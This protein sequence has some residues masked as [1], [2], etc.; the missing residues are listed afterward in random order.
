MRIVV[1]GK[2]GQLAQALAE[3]GPAAGATVRMLGRPEFDLAHPENAREALAAL[4]PDVVV[5]AAAYTAV[6]KAEDEPQIA[7]AVNAGGPRALAR[8]AAELRVPLIHVSTDYVFDGT[9]PA[10]WTEDDAPAPLGVY[11]AS[12]RAGEVAVLEEAPGSVVLRIGWVYS[13][14]ATNFAKTVLRLAG[15]R[16]VLRIVD[17]QHGGPTSALDAADGILSVARNIAARR[18]H[19]TLRGI[20]HMGPAGEATWAD[21]AAAVCTWLAS[22][23]GRRAAVERIATADYPTKARRPA[24]SRLDSR[25][26]AEA[27]GVRLP[28]WRLSLPKVLERLAPAPSGHSPV[29]TEKNA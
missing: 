13:P 3:R 4:E 17:D 26:L 7:F 8:A 2:T 20:F 24:N 18:D 29:V 23:R 28:D 9:K 16:D 6:D 10:P 19:E 21:F 22:N 1:T 15:E 25:R 27:H 11:G 5:S 14:F 12:K